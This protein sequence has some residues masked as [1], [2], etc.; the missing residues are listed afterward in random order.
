M[1]AKRIAAVAN[2]LAALAAWPAC[3]QQLQVDFAPISP[4][5]ISG[6]VIAAIAGTLAF[7]AH[8]V[9]RGRARKYTTMVSIGA[10]AAALA[11]HVVVPTASYAF[12]DTTIVNLTSSPATVTL[13]NAD[14]YYQ[15][16]NRAG[17]TIRILSIE[18]VNAPGFTFI[19]A[20]APACDKEQVLLQ[21]QFC[22][23]GLGPSPP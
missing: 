19:S 13:V 20:A 2:V 3:A 15:L 22:Y 16:V 8:R 4:I 23:V 11:W 12:L 5:P 10:A 7:A 14:Q 9:L 18:R 1:H 17:T 6:W 21:N